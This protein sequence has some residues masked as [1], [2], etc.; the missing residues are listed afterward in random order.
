MASSLCHTQFLAC[1][2]LLFVFYVNSQNTPIGGRLR[3][4]SYGV[5]PSFSKDDLPAAPTIS[6]RAVSWRSFHAF[7]A[8]PPWKCSTKI[9]SAPLAQR[10]NPPQV[11]NFR[12]R[13]A[14]RHDSGRHRCSAPSSNVWRG[15]HR[16][17][18]RFAASVGRIA[19][20]SAFRRLSGLMGIVSSLLARPGLP[21]FR[22]LYVLI[23]PRIRMT[24]SG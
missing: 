23:D 18:N 6:L 10:L 24:R 13:H 11:V 2:S 5:C 20:T 12:P 16:H 3:G 8:H 1:I 7:S 19:F 21:P 9:T 17:R 22:H 4:K 15:R 14:Q